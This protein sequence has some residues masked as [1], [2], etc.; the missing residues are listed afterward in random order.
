MRLGETGLD[1]L[2]NEAQFL[3]RDDG[4]R[5]ALT[6]L[7][8]IPRTRLRTIQPRSPRHCRRMEPR[9]AAASNE[10]PWVIL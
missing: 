4:R 5:R 3:L 1:D 10:P 9:N 8:T 2:L 6:L 7:W